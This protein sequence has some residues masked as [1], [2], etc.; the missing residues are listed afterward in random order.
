MFLARLSY[1]KQVPLHS[2]YALQFLNWPNVDLKQQ[3][4][5]NC[6]GMTRFGTR[7]HEIDNFQWKLPGDAA[8]AGPTY[9]SVY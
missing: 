2:V 8:S 3:K 6:I 5:N 9:C 7:Y 4:K 1:L